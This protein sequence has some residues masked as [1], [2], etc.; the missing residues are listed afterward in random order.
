MTRDKNRHDKFLTQKN[1]REKNPKGEKLKDPFYSIITCTLNSAKY[2]KQTIQSVE[3]QSYRAFEHIFYR[4]V[5][6]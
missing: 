5:F 6:R 1:L 2:I 3:S 4:W